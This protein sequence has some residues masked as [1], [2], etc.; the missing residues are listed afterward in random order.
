MPIQQNNGKTTVQ[1]TVLRALKG[2]F[3]AEAI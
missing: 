2:Y 1:I 3:C